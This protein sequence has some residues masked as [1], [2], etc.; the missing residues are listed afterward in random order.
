M[1][2]PSCLKKKEEERSTNEGSRARNKAKEGYG[3]GCRV[4]GGEGNAC[5]VDRSVGRVSG[6]TKREKMR[7]EKKRS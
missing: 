6:V 4:E 7:E 2:V 5:V 1:V 3:R